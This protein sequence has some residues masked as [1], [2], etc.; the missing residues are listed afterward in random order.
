[1]AVV[2]IIQFA[3]PTE[4]GVCVSMGAWAGYSS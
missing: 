4:V 3:D 1:M 2:Q